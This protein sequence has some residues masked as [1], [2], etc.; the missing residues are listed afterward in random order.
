VSDHLNHAR[1]QLFHRLY[2]QVNSAAERAIRLYTEEA[3]RVK[4]EWR[5]RV[6]YHGDVAGISYMGDG[7]NIKWDEY[8]RNCRTDGGNFT[9]PWEALA[10]GTQKDFISD[11]VAKQVAKQNAAEVEKSAQELAYK[12]A[13]LVKLKVE[14]GEA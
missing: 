10:D 5:D 4:L 9:L 12:R 11:L 7:V 1:L 6:W 14:L 2:E 8:R 13:Q 3:D